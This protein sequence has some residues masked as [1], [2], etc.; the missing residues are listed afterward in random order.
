MSKKKGDGLKSFNKGFQVPD[1]YIIIFFVVVIAAVM[2]FLVPK[3]YYETQD[4]TYMMNGVEKTRT[5]IKDGSFQYLRDDAGK[6]VTE[7]VA[8]FSGDGGTGFFNYMYNGIVNSSAIEIIAFLM[9]VGG[10]FG[11][12]IRTGAIEAGLIGLI[13]KAEGA[14]KLLI[15]VLFVLF[16]LGGA[17]FGMGEE[18]LPFTMILCPLFVAV[19]YDTVIAVLVTYVATQIGFGSSWMNPFS[20]GI[21][22]GIAGIDVF[23]GAGFRMV[24]W[25][26]FTALGCGM[27]IFYAAKVKKNPRI[28]VAYESDQYF[29]DQNEK[30]GIDEGHAFGIGHVL[31]LLTLAATVIWVVWGVMTKG[32]YMPEIAT[33]FFIM[34]IVS[35]VIGVIFKLNDIASSFKDGAKDLIGAALVVAMAQGIMQVLGGSDPTTPTVI[36]TIMYNIANA[37]SGVSGAVA[38]VL[39]YLFQSV[40]NFFVVSGTGQAAITMPI[41]APLSDLLGVTRQTSVVAFQLGD[42]F[43]NLIVPTSGCLI[44]SL[45]IAKIEWSNWIKFMWKFLGVLMI[46]AIITV[47][48]AV[49]IGF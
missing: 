22:Q 36:N 41:M 26:V 19:G 35:G 2:T 8:L 28:S 39:M 13:R 1:T 23:S 21:A 17:V 9:I 31:V 43:T 40:F 18:A 5:V 45:A 3:G 29:R 15:P 4:V 27:T 30:T 46:G 20:V 11:I 16:S 12:M 44:G 14:E 25:V 32:Y 10:A 48:I 33:Q 7:G 34:G 47:L 6:V 37:L 42:A 24:M 38:A 49:G